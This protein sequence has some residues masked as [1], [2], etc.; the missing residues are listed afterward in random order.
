MTLCVRT[1]H[2]IDA[3]RVRRIIPLGPGECQVQYVDDTG[4]LIMGTVACS[5]SILRQLLEDETTA[6]ARMACEELG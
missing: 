4:R 1:S 2:L 5:A 3:A 6:D